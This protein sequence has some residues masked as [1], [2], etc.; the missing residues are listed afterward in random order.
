MRSASAK[1]RCVRRMRWHVGA[2]VAGTVVVASA[3]GDPTGANLE[4]PR[5]ELRLQWSGTTQGSFAAIG[6]FPRT[7]FDYTEPV[8]YSTRG[9]FN[10]RSV[11]M[12]IASRPDSPYLQ[13]GRDQVTIV[14]DQSVT[15]PGRYGPGSCSQVAVLRDCFHAQVA[16]GVPPGAGGTVS[17]V[18]NS[19]PGQATLTIT[20]WA[21]D[22]VV[23]TFEGRF[24]Y[25]P[26][27]SGGAPGDTLTIT[28]GFADAT[29]PDGDHWTP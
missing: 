22:R 2:C 17:W 20:H 29:N 28:G 4:P 27:I 18:V 25:L 11:R 6:T 15:G 8:V 16:L 14:V 24:E 1:R 3:C 12:I 13:G 9:L 21:P 10:G 19:I 5:H 26:G 23:A 7:P